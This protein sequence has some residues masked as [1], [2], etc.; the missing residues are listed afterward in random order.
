MAY[1]SNCQVAVPTGS[2]GGLAGLVTGLERTN[3]QKTDDCETRHE[4]V[5]TIKKKRKPVD[6]SSAELVKLHSDNETIKAR[7]FTYTV[8]ITFEF[9]VRKSRHRC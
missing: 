4:N 1:R 7:V 5:L 3:E 8:Y 6:S 9:N 2:S